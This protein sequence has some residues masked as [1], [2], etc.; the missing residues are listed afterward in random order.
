MFKL[1]STLTSRFPFLQ[2][3]N[4]SENEA[5][6]EELLLDSSADILVGTP[7]KILEITKKKSGLLKK[8]KFVVLD[9]ADLLFSYGYKDELV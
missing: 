9:E 2:S 1:L 8:I 5:A 7:G 3:I 6:N 4:L